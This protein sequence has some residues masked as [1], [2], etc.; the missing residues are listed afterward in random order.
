LTRINLYVRFRHNEGLVDGCFEAL[1]DHT[2]LI[3]LEILVFI[4]AVGW[5]LSPQSFVSPAFATDD[6]FLFCRIL[7]INIFVL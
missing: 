5:Y 6:D 7:L 2:V 3:D 1:N 4:S